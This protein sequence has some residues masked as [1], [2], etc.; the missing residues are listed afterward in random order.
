MRA[1]R[2]VAALIGI[3]IPIFAHA[4][5]FGIVVGIRIPWTG[6]LLVPKVAR[7]RIGLSH[8]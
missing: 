7:S 1:L 6:C 4:T 3:A 8:R 2:M 5:V